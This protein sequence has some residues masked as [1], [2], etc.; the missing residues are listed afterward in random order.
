MSTITIFPST[1][2]RRA[3]PAAASPALR[4]TRRG[5][6]VLVATFLAVIAVA[7]VAL[8]G[9]AIGT[10]DSGTPEP[11]RTIEVGPGDTLYAIAGT[12]ARPGHVREM[13]DRIEQ[14]N[15]LT[16]PELQIGQQLAVPLH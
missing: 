15:A 5:R 12:V 13:I 3:A 4:L 2:T 8:G 9:L 7:M 6:L 11:V 10:R 16:G 1:Y 14:L